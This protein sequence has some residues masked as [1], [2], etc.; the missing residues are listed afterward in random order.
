MFQLTDLWN[1]NIPTFEDYGQWL[2]K[3]MF[4]LNSDVLANPEDIVDPTSVATHLYK[5]APEILAMLGV[6]Y[7]VSDGNLDHPS[8]TEVLTETSPALATDINEGGRAI[9]CH[10]CGGA[11]YDIAGV[12]ATFRQYQ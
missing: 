7:I 3:Q 5:F 12:A 2:T 10:V 1:S 11:T 6:R 8:V 4:V 9:S